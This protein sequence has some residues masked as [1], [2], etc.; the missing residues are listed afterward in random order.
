M[1]NFPSLPLKASQVH[2]RELQVPRIS[3]QCFLKSSCGCTCISQVPTYA[4]HVLFC[5]IHSVDCMA[6]LF[7]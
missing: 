4:L 6:P 2:I 3:W 5:S 1:H 7:R